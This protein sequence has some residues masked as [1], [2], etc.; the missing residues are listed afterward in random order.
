MRITEVEELMTARRNE[1]KEFVIASKADLEIL[2]QHLTKNFR[3]KERPEKK[4]AVQF[5]DTFDWKLF[6]HG[7][8]MEKTGNRLCLCSLDGTLVAN[9]AVVAKNCF[10]AAD[11]GQGVLREKLEALTQVRAFLAQASVEK[12]TN[13][14]D[15]LNKDRK[16]VVRVFLDQA[17]FSPGDGVEN[18][19]SFLRFA[20]VRGYEK[21]FAKAVEI[22]QKAGLAELAEEQN[23]FHQTLAS[24]GRQA[25]DYRSKFEISL[26]KNC[27]VGSA[28]HSICKQLMET[29]E[30]N[31][32]GLLEDIDSEF[33]H[34]FR[35]AIRR[36][37]SLLGQFKKSFSHEE[38]TRLQKELKWL[39]TI[40][41][42]VRDLDVYLL[43]KK[44]FRSILP[45]ALQRGLDEFFVDLQKSR[46]EKL[47][48]M[49]K[50]LTSKRYQ[51]FMEQ[52]RQFLNQ[53]NSEKGMHGISEQS[54]LPQA[55][56]KI[57]KC[58]KKIIKDGSSID[59]SSSDEQL[60]RL[61]IQGKKLRYLIEF[62]RSFFDEEEIEYFRKQLK[63]LQDM[64]GDFND[65]SV[66]MNML[67]EN[68]QN[69]SGRTKRSIAIAATIGGLQIHLHQEKEQSRKQFTT[70]FAEF[71]SRENIS[72]FNA[73]LS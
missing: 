72:R 39:G 12:I 20:E 25:G 19:P 50:G 56:K 26:D 32:Q 59:S 7:L 24:G 21:S 63:K 10:F 40:T 54:C 71:G 28:L 55:R 58:L 15:L 53:F 41:G 67:M 62:F 68:Q 23:F 48:T 5:Y 36:A 35:V 13:E 11:L 57:S 31:L 9:E 69:L 4:A 73:L 17:K 44:E 22:A 34:D 37:R 14:I 45:R 6:N 43:R 47:V 3:F 42:P 64:L 2:F 18:G 51:D 27:T 60:H 65:I 70:T 33:L 66:E 8:L 29:M 38:I 49:K 61:R 30:V 52:W 46:D 16:I 1:T